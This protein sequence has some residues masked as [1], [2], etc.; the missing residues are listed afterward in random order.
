MLNRLPKETPT[1]AELRRDLGNPKAC[2]LSKALGVSRRTIDRWTEGGSPR[3]ARLA[4]WWLS[5]WGH[6]AWDCEMQNRTA[7]AVQTNEALWR[8]VRMLRS[9]TPAF[10]GATQAELDDEGWP[11]RFAV[12]R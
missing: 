11:R 7:L 3:A 4:L 2:E 5:Q 8:E 9:R 12:R 6:S 1:F 10:E